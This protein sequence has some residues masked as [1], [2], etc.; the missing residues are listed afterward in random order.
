MSVAVDEVWAEILAPLH[1]T[2]GVSTDAQT[3]PQRG[4]VS[5]AGSSRSFLTRR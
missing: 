3:P 1:S 4:C 5:I 2:G